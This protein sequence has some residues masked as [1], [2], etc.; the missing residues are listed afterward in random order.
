MVPGGAVRTFTRS[1]AEAA[2]AAWYAAMNSAE[3][4]SPGSVTRLWALVGR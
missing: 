3:P 4:A 1:G 2:S